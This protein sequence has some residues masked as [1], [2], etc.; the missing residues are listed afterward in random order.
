MPVISIFFG[1]VI[2]MYHDDHPPPHFHATYSGDSAQVDIETLQILDG[3]LPPRALH[4]VQEWAELHR[5]E[6]RDNWQR[7][8]AHEPL[9]PIDPLP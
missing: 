3:W 2:R 8:V 7:A 4:L 9:V 6:L 1:I 5:Q